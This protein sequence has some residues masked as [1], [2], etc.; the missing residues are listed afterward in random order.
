MLKNSVFYKPI[1]RK[2]S[3]A[4]RGYDYKGKILKNTMSEAMF[5]N[6]EFLYNFL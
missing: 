4:Y 6:G 2:E 1:H 3:K 5:N